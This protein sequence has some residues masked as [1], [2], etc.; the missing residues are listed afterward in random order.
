MPTISQIGLI[1]P[2]VFEEFEDIV[3]DYFSNILSLQFQK[4][5]RQ[6]Q[7]QNG[8]DLIGGNIGVQCKNYRTKKLTIEIIENDVLLAEE[9][10]PSLSK[11]YFV[12]T[13]KR[14]AKIQQY[15]RSRK[16]KIPIEIHYW[17]LIENFLLQNPK[18]KDLHYPK[19][20]EINND[21]TVINQFLRLCNVYNIY[22]AI[23]EVDYINPYGDDIIYE[24]DVFKAEM[25]A[26]IN[27]DI[28][29][30]VNKEILRDLENFKNIY[31]RMISKATMCSCPNGAGM[32]IPNIWFEYI[33]SH[34]VFFVDHRTKLSVIYSKY[35]FGKV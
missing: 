9:I 20:I 27:S 18:V 28:S 16:G 1:P 6:G 4:W 17:D 15:F 7:K 13:A 35:K 26:L 30:G 25:T 2:E 34:R 29:I 12:T 8:I 31:S 14:D 5:G 22:T 10:S 19:E 11:L 23:Y 3:C 21:Q 24:A 33:E 32:S